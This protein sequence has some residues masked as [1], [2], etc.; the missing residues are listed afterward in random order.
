VP[1]C[2]PESPRFTTRSERLVWEALREQ[3]GPD[4]LL[5]AN[6]RITDERKDHEADVVVALP[7]AGIVVVEVKGGELTHDG[8][9]WW[10]LR[11]GRWAAVD[12]VDQARSTKYALRTYVESDPRWTA[13][14]KRRIRWGHAVALA[15][16]RLPDD[17]AL[18][19][20]PRWQVIGRDDIDVL[21]ERLRTLLLGL[22]T[23]NRLPEDDDVAVLT[24]VLRGRGLP[25]RDLLA[26]AA[27]RDTHVKQLTQDQAVVLGATRQLNR[28]D[29]RG[30]A[31]SGKTWLALEQASRLSGDGQRVA[32]T[33]YSRGL[34][35]FLRRTVAVWPADR[36][37]AYVGEF[38]TL[39]EQ[40]GAAPGRDDDSDYWERRLPAQM[41]EL[42]TQL[43]DEQR[44]DAVVVDEAQDFAESWWPA[45][46]T[47]L[48]DDETGGVYA[49]TDAGQRVFARYGDPPVP[50]VPIVLDH[51]VRNTRQIADAF[52]PLAP[53][54][55]RLLGEEGPHVRFI[56][57]SATDAIGVGDDQVDVLLGHGWRPEHVALLTT[58]SRHPEQ[59]TRQ[60]SGHASYWASCWDVEQVF[61]GHVLG[62]KGLERRAVVFVLNEA[63]PRERSRE[64]LYVG[65]SR[66]RD[67]LVVVGDPDYVR[68]VGGPEVAERLDLPT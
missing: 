7:G 42:A 57:C 50:L 28:V 47:A 54:R 23:T 43:P 61:Y 36:Q 30:G 12:P 37:P 4:A 31:G 52:G 16:T 26:R 62:F 45:L 2:L 14:G 10:H 66:A 1:I 40:W 58:G 38:F 56:E 9:T 11:R 44:F 59:V 49:F 41:V 24:S 21:A 3:L 35:E 25:Q 15:H 48:R 63:E 65:L 67:E 27:A 13:A 55:M 6:L 29:I 53:M 60:A 64:R 33:C 51:N 8:E 46:L 5:L 68:E 32:L 17:F 19:Q 22:R 39:G 20:A 18:P 34:A